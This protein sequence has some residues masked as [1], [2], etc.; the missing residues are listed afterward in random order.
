MELVRKMLCK[1]VYSVAWMWKN[2]RLWYETVLQK[3]NEFLKR[4]EHRRKTETWISKEW[5]GQHFTPQRKEFSLFSGKKP[6]E[7]RP[8]DSTHTGYQNIWSKKWDE[9]G[10]TSLL[11]KESKGTIYRWKM[12]DAMLVGIMEQGKERVNCKGIFLKVAAMKG[13]LPSECQNA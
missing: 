11:W 12:M 13:P 10:T 8:S 1:V 5:I 7:S 6:M 3:I 4:Q 2:W 9:G